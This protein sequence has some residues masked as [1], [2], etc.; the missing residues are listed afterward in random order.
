MGHLAE[1]H[2]SSIPPG[3]FTYVADPTEFSSS[4]SSS[5]SSSTSSTS[6]GSSVTIEEGGSSVTI[7]E[8][9]E[10]VDDDTNVSSSLP[11]TQEEGDGDDEA[12]WNG[13]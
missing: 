9:R 4:S 6:G 11:A 8:V 10:D 2:A 13:W 1:S 5:S 7:E 12:E 3:S